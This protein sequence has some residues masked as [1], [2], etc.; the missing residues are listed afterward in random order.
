MTNR[1]QFG[2]YLHEH[3]IVCFNSATTFTLTDHAFKTT[4][5]ILTGDD[6]FWYVAT[7]FDKEP[8]V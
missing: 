8:Y 7:I 2:E 3:P 6:S 5:A 1:R 4:K